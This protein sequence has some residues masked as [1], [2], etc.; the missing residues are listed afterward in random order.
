M[1]DVH[2]NVDGTPATQLFRRDYS[3]LLFAVTHF[4]R[5]FNKCPDLLKQKRMREFQPPECGA[6]TNLGPSSTCPMAAPELA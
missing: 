2:R 6:V 3:S 4:A 1:T 5:H